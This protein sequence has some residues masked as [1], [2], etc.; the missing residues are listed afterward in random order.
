MGFISQGYVFNS[1]ITISIGRDKPTI[2]AVSPHYINFSEGY[3]ML[4]RDQVEVWVM[5]VR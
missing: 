1:N 5:G 2:Y 3:I 4:L